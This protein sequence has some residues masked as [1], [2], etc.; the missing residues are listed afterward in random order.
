ML[1]TSLAVPYLAV[2]VTAV[3]L[4]LVPDGALSGYDPL[5]L[6]LVLGCLFILKFPLHII[7]RILLLVPYFVIMRY[8]LGHFG[9]FIERVLSSG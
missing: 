6:P 8:P 4:A 9:W 1:A 7:W 2:F 3:V 5:V